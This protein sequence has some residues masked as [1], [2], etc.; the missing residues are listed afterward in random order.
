MSSEPVGSLAE[1]AAKLFAVVQ[2]WAADHTGRAGADSSPDGSAKDRSTGN[3]GA[4]DAAAE[5]AHAAHDPSTECRWCPL[6]QLV[7]VAKATTPEVRDHLTSAAFSLAMAFKGLM[8][9]VDDASQRSEPVERIDLDLD[10]DPD[11]GFDA[12][13]PED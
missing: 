4:A 2:G 6:C 5:Q 10:P 9:S 1:E 12:G 13:S 8:E 3:P 7:R 11:P